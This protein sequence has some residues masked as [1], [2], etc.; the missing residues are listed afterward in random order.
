[1]ISQIL[2]EIHIYYSKLAF[3]IEQLCG[4]QHA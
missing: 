1:M 2:K 3:T 4:E